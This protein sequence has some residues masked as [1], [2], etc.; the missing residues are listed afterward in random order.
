MRRTC[1]QQDA[2]S[3]IPKRDNR[4]T[5]PCQGTAHHSSWCRWM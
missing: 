3:A 2:T 1:L 4:R 5:R